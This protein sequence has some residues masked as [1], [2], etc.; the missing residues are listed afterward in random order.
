MVAG[1]DL[2]SDKQLGRIRVKLIQ[3]RDRESV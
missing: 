3:L 2:G 1:L